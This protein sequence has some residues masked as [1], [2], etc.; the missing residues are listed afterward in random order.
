[1]KHIILILALF[2]STQSF[3]QNFVM[4]WQHCYGGS[5]DDMATSIIADENGYI[6]TGITSSHDGD[7]S[8][9]PIIRSTW[10]VNIDKYGNI[11]FDTC[12]IGFGDYSGGLKLLSI[13]DGYYLTGISGPNYY[14]GISGYWMA[15]IDSDFNILW[16]NIL[17]GTSGESP[18]A[19][20]VAHDGGI[21]T[22]GTTKSSDGDIELY[23][24]N[25]DNWLVKLKPDGSKDWLKTYGNVWL[26]IGGYII[27]TNEGGYAYACSGVDAEPGNIYC[28]DYEGSN[29]GGWL[30]KL[31][32]NGEKIWNICYGGTENDT[33]KDIIQTDDGGFIVVGN[34]SSNDGDLNYH[35]GIPGESTDIWLIKLNKYG[36]IIW[37]K[38]YGG[39]DR[40]YGNQ[41]F[42]NDNNTYTIFGQTTSHDY[43][44]QGN[45]NTSNTEIVWMFNID[46]NGDLLYQK[47][48]GE[49]SFLSGLYDFA[50]VSDY[51]YIAAV[52]RFAPD[53]CYT[54]NPSE[55]DEGIYVFEIQDMDEFIPAQPIGSDRVCL[56]LEAESY[57]STQLVID[58]METQWLLTPEEAGIITQM[59]DSV[60][61][62]WNTN[63]ADTAWL[64]VRAVN[65]Y[66]ESSYSV[67]KEIIVHA[68]L[69]FS[70]IMGP[71]SVC[72]ANN[73]LSFFSTQIIDDLKLNWY[74]E[75]ENAGYINNQQ[76]TAIIS[77]NVAFEG[78]VSLKT[79]GTNQCD[80][81]EYSEIK[82]VSVK[83]CTGLMEYYKKEL[84]LHPNPTQTHLTFELPPITT[85]ITLHIT[86][87]FGKTIAKLLLIKGQTKLVWNCSTVAS[88]VYFYQTEIDGD[89]YRGKIIVN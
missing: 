71:D 8:N 79:S 39:T 64:Q 80:E 62:H 28:D 24:G 15:K 50:R 5:E 41:I 44:V 26:E 68:P 19:G 87:I 2:I 60:F 49:L 48:F 27:P 42:K 7:I 54:A 4:T 82:E 45:T 18:K 32:A 1:M 76:D 30:I 86:D 33:F 89:V 73:Q 29:Y 22:T 58:T 3:S 83:T 53:N 9:N 85:E 34:S 13:S 72:T 78:V 20:C 61:I 84:N 36:E 66:G 25:S 31:D 10:L 52:T 77:W 43:D 59:H 35:Y 51:K 74:L 65:E 47:P 57:Y 75:P 17:G 6:F 67:S 38:T 21:I 40:D 14:G 69:N 16:Q 23:F 12:Y 56:G 46:G 11:I 70:T 88:G 81:S 63:F 55:Y 37:S